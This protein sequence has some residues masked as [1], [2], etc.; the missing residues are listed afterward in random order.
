MQHHGF[1]TRLLDW[2]QSLPAAL[3]FATRDIRATEDGAIWVLAT[4]YLMELSGTK[5]ATQ[6]SSI[7]PPIEQYLDN[8]FPEK[9]ATLHPIPLH[10][11][12]L[13]PRII[14]QAGRFTLHS[15]QIQ[16]LE[17]LAEADRAK[18]GDSAFLQVIR[19]PRSSKDLFRRFLPL[20]GATED[21][22]FPDLDGLARSIR[23][24][25]LRRGLMT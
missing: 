14:A 10:P 18:C 9:L 25:F 22:L 5:G 7:H 1:P 16:A 4:P 12:H 23:M 17:T 3:H 6:F 11:E 8:E 15:Y 24:E 21:V 2:T 20:L 19:I 13:S